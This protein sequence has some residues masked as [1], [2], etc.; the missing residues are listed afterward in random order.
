M[1]FSDVVAFGG[2]EIRA[3]GGVCCALIGGTK[4]SVSRVV[5]FAAEFMD[6]LNGSEINVDG[7]L[8]ILQ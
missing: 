5:D 6:N 3:G 7:L 4:M 2:G 1:N 8:F